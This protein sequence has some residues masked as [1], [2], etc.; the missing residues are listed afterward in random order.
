MTSIKGAGI[1]VKKARVGTSYLDI[2]TGQEWI[3]IK[4]PSGSDWE[5]KVDSTETLDL[6][7][8]TE[9]GVETTSVIQKGFDNTAF[10]T[11]ANILGD[12]NQANAPYSY[13]RGLGVTA[14]NKANPFEIIPGER[15]IIIPDID[16]AD[17]YI[18]G[19]TATVMST[20]R[21]R[22]TINVASVF[23]G[24][25]TGTTTGT[26]SGSTSG[27]T[28]GSTSGITSGLTLW[29]AI[30][31]EEPLDSSIVSGVVLDTESGTGACAE[32]INTHAQGYASHAEGSNTKASGISSHAEGI[33]T[34]AEA[35]GS[36]AGGIFS[37]AIH[38]GEWVRSSSYFNVV[39]DAQYMTFNMINTSTGT[40]GSTGFTEVFID[41]LSERITLENNCSYLINFNGLSVIVADY[42]SGSYV[43][44]G[45]SWSLMGNMIDNINGTITFNVNKDITVPMFYSSSSDYSNNAITFWPVVQGNVFK[46]LVKGNPGLVY[47]T[48]IKVDMVKIKFD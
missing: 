18:A 33:G 14:G 2:Q 40:T 31:I 27:I 26:T 28:T 25:T 23:T 13:A 17:V 16:A 41:G 24:S 35:S 5:R 32:G 30:E 9:K 12:F 6:A 45:S 22:Y 37:Q 10:G 42:N 43:G 38:S 11:Y 39:G 47:R 4:N 48:N 46:I 8:H 29:T 44:Q 36:N 20:D 3:Q 19:G 7:Q 1:P 21:T 34:I 15:F